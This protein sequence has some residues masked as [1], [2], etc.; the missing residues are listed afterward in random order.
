MDESGALVWFCGDLSDPFLARAAGVIEA[1]APC[2]A[3]ESA[4]ALGDPAQ[5]QSPRVIVAH[6][7]RLYPG[8]LETLAR[9]RA[10]WP[11]VSIWL[12]A[13]PYLRYAETTRLLPLVDQVAPEATAGF[14]IPLR[15]R[16]LLGLDAG[17]DRAPV[18][19][20]EVSSGLEELGRVL[21]DACAR[22]GHAVE[23]VADLRHGRARPRCAGA[24]RVVTVWDVPVLEPGW[25]ACL[26]ER[27]RSVGPVV[28]LLG[29]A[30]RAA[31]ARAETAGASA[32]LDS[33]LDL[34]LVADAVDAVARACERECHAVP[35]RVDAGH[36]LPPRPRQ[37]AQ[38]PAR[39]RAAVDPAR[40]AAKR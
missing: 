37:G 39:R 34:D 35:G 3:L 26:E 25:E 23:V 7:H 38:A 40:K 27:V 21:A 6:R 9:W 22:A 33:P 31:V 19:R 8:D 1:V 10:Q 24:E 15:L 28:A 2:L 18:D 14:A 29:Y 5:A 30:D 36:R 16:R 20:V 4:G 17:D 12:L 13:S 11:G 32:C